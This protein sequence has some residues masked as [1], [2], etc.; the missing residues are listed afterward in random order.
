MIN[1][2]EETKKELDVLIGNLKKT[3]ENDANFE[4]EEDNPRCLWTDSNRIDYPIEKYLITGEGRCNWENMIY[5]EDKGGFWIHAG[6][7]DS[8]GWLTG[9]IE[10]SK[11]VN[12]EKRKMI[13][14]G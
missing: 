10:P 1:I 9:V 12:W 2:N 3:F 6:E 5:L 11:H 4:A 7:K 8:F 14:Y 13:V